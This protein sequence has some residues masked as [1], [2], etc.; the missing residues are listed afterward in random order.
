LK[1]GEEEPPEGCA[2]NIVNQHCEINLLLK[3]MIDAAAEIKKLQ[4]NLD[5]TNQQLVTLQ[6]RM[7][8]KEYMTKVPE[9][10][11]KSNDERVIQL[12]QEIESI[13]LAIAKFEK[14]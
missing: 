9:N 11:R 8:A 5:K 2:V 6:K 12:Q 13:K 4:K 3:G 10:V 1:K 14:L 7:T